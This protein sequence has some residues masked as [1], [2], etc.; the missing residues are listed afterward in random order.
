MGLFGSKNVKET[1]LAYR[2]IYDDL[3]KD[4]YDDFIGN[5]TDNNL[6]KNVECKNNYLNVSILDLTFAKNNDDN[7]RSC[8]SVVLVFQVD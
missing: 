4:F 5:F 2:Y 6:K 8:Y 3:Y 7:F 1:E